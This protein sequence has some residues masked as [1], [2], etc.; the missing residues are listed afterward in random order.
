[1]IALAQAQST[2][3]GR[4][5]GIY[6]EVKL[7]TFHANL[8]GANVFENQLVSK[9]HTAYGNSRS[10]PVFIQSLE[11]ANLQYM[12]GVT[13]IKLVRLIAADDVN[14]AGLM[15]HTWTYRNDA[16]GYGFSNPQ[17][18]M[19]YYLRL[20]VDG[21]FT[22]FPDTGVAAVASIREP[23]TYAMLLSGLLVVAGVARRRR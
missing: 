23:G 9:L 12:N 14:A 10:A 13:D 6:P 18:E 19:A 5:I 16:S 1:M 11:S 7:S 3:T 20:G 4:T 2:A 15:M 21:V 22:D 8:F 17:E